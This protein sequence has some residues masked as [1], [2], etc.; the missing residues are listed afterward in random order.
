MSDEARRH[1]SSESPL[2][3]DAEL[4][5]DIEPVGIPDDNGRFLKAATEALIFASAEP[6]T[7]SQ[8]TAALGARVKGELPRIVAEL[9]YEYQR[10][11]RAFE[12]LAV[13]GGYQFFTRRDFSGVLRRL[14]LARARTRLSRAALETLAV[15]AYRGPV[16]HAEIDE[17]R[18]VDCGGVLRTLL[19]RRLLAVKGR[20]QVLGRPLLYETTPE[21]LK[22]FGLSDLSDL[23]RDSELLREWGQPRNIEE[24]VPAEALL[25]DSSQ[26][27]ITLAE[28]QGNGRMPAQPVEENESE[29]DM[30][31]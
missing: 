29:K 30:T 22:H 31:P 13:A 25:E 2:P 16:T 19:D 24:T 9:N 8:L 27:N 17:I 1:E 6:L 7:E 5:L 23:P 26:V 3:E 12:I 11:G 28:D 21:F 10:D 18:G 15:V 20:A 4:P 14:S